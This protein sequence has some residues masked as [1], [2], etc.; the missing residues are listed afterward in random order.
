MIYINGENININENVKYKFYFITD[1]FAI[2]IVFHTIADVVP[3]II[4]FFQ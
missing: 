3:N 1:E 4:I 2:K